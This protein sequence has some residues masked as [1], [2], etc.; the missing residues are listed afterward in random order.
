[1][2]RIRSGIKSPSASI[3]TVHDIGERGL[4]RKLLKKIPP[5]HRNPIGIGDDAA[6]LKPSPGKV[7]LISTDTLVEGIDFDLR[8]HK[9]FR[10]IGHKAL[11][12]NMSDIAAM[13]GHP[14]AFVLSLSTPK[15]TPVK[16]II[17][18]FSG[19]LS[20]AQRENVSLIGGDLSGSR[21]DLSLTIT[22]LGEIKKGRA[23]TRAGAHPG[24]LLFVSGPLGDSRAGLEVIKNR[25]RKPAENHSKWYGLVRSH[26]RPTAQTDL[27]IWL[28]NGRWATAMIDISDG[29]A[30]DVRNLCAASHVGACIEAE[31]TPVSP[32][33]RRY[34]RELGVSPWNYAIQGGEDFQ[35]L[36]SVSPKRCPLFIRAS[37][38][39]GF[40]VYPIGKVVPRNLGVTFINKHGRITPVK[41][42]GYEHFK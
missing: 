7:L 11:A 33:L 2:S 4:L 24:D 34:C 25:K 38:R 15:F 41:I 31:R 16:H 37:K 23:V 13:G 40:R 29:L 42:R 12:V 36:F 9:P 5:F 26:L 35:L 3:K 27:G 17:E 8:L 32:S 28:A 30:T 22:I 21:R 1:M 10:Y 18:I 6:I 14:I 19:I 39:A 20:L